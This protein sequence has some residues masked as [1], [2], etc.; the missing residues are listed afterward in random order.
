MTI[1]A[2]AETEPTDAEIAAL[3]EPDEERVLVVLAVHNGI[4]TD[5]HPMLVPSTYAI[6]VS[7]L[8]YVQRYID[9]FSI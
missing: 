5:G 7:D 3:V 1:P 6:P 4:V 9:K 8:L 2:S